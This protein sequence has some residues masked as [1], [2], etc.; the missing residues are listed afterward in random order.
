MIDGVDGATDVSTEDGAE[1]EGGDPVDGGM[2]P[3]T[4]SVERLV[5]LEAVVESCTSDVV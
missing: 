2:P 4:A 1:D 5:I 3:V